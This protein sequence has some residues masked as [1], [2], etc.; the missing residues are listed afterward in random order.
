MAALTAPPASPVTRPAQTVAATTTSAPRTVAITN[1]PASLIPVAVTPTPTK[2]LEQV[3][4]KAAASQPRPPAVVAP[5]PTPPISPTPPSVVINDPLSVAVGGALDVTLP[6]LGLGTSG[7]TF[8]ITPQPLPANMLFNR[9]TGELTFTPAPDQHG[10]FD[11]SVAVSNGSRFGQ[12]ALPI[13]VTAPTL[14]ST[15]ISGQVVD[16]NGDPLADMPVTIAGISTVTNSSG[17][18]TLTDV[19]DNPGPISAGGS[20]GSE[21]GRLDL[22]APVAQLL[23]HDLYADADNV[24]H[25]P[26]IL[27]MIN[28]SSP[29]SFTQAPSA[30]SVNIT[31]PAMPGLSVQMP[32]SAT[33]ISPASGTVQVAQLP[34]A[35]S[36]QHMAQGM[37]SP[38]ILLNI[39]G[40][41]LNSSAQLTLPNIV[42]LQPGAIAY[43]T[44][45]NPITGGHDVVG[46]LVVSDDGE[47][48]TST[49]MINLS[50]NANY[51]EPGVS[52]DLVTP[53]YSS[54]FLGSTDCLGIEM[55]PPTEGPISTSSSSSSSSTCNCSNSLSYGGPNGSPGG[56]PGGGPKG[57]MVPAGVM[58]SSAGLVTGAYFLNNQLMTYQVQGQTLGINLQYSSARPTPR[59]PSS[60]SL[61]RRS[62]ATPLRS[63]R[64]PPR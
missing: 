63:P 52:P 24:I 48:M 26:L 9:Q 46:R 62:T 55:T 32:V 59:Q 5:A 58:D 53:D 20:V 29:T 50:T 42:G 38:L 45:F 25:S 19:P 8:T 33:A 60:M 56:G 15:E 37:S 11:F 39:S 35:V 36:V 40:S 2:L 44:M 12:I 47:T 4:A 41:N 43:L 17:D 28:W 13:T 21:Q 31:T 34:A 14:S 23:G 10:E 3:F 16:E 1:A 54:P 57:I 27:P 61:R 18:F 51:A 64:S 6:N 49:G 22:T 7:L 30:T